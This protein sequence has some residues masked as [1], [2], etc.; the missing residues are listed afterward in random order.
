M[1][2]SRTLLPGD[3]FNLRASW[4]PDILEPAGWQLV[5]RNGRTQYWRRPGKERG[6]SA[7][8]AYGW[9]DYLYVFSTNATL[10]P[11]RAFDKF[12][13]YTPVPRR[14][15]IRRDKSSGLAWIRSRHRRSNPPP[16]CKER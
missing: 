2:S 10:D 16:D 4:G 9:G 12:G 1:Y 6:V 15:H 3:D 11:H 5:F 13:A 7:T 14:R 8:T